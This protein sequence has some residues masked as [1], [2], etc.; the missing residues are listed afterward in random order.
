MGPPSRN[1]PALFET[2]DRKGGFSTHEGMVHAVNGVNL[3]VRRGETLAVVGESGSGKSVSALSVM[4][5]MMTST[6]FTL[7]SMRGL[8][9]NLLKTQWRK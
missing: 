8:L 5:L 6:A 7:H 9:I 1:D 2:H 4:G 3:S